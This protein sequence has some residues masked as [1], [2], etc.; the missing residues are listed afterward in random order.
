MTSN[1]RKLTWIACP[2]GKAS[3]ALPPIPL[4]TGETLVRGELSWMVWYEDDNPD[5]YPVQTL[6]EG[7]AY[8]VEK[9]GNV[10]N[11]VEVHPGTDLQILSTVANGMKIETK[12]VVQPRHIYLTFDPQAANNG[13][14]TRNLSSG[15]RYE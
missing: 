15:A 8:Y 1:N 10:P 11:R 6:I 14:P 4:E 2:L 13:S 7:T 9:Y 12:I 3:T 5:G